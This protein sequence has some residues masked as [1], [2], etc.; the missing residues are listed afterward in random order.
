MVSCLNHS[1]GKK[2]RNQSCQAQMFKPPQLFHWHT[3]IIHA[4][5]HFWEEAIEESPQTQLRGLERFPALRWIHG[6]APE[7]NSLA[8]ARPPCK[9]NGDPKKHM[10][11]STQLQCDSVMFIGPKGDH[12]QETHVSWAFWGRTQTDQIS[13]MVILECKPLPTCL[14]PQSIR[15]NQISQ[16]WDACPYMSVLTH[17]TYLL[18]FVHQRHILVAYTSTI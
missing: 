4:E 12:L 17:P 8:P 7:S 3:W 1:E 18:K 6:V 9:Q 10:N 14:W 15:F 2:Q 16:I 5:R 13:L 11:T